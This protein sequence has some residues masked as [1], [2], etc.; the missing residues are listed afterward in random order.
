MP[1]LNQRSDAVA[2]GARGAR[3][4]SRVREP[5][6][7][8]EHESLSGVFGARADR[9]ATAARRSRRWE[10]ETRAGDARDGRSAPSSAA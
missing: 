7:A 4:V 8:R 3:R 9:H 10:A 6:P 2:A 5:A 1:A